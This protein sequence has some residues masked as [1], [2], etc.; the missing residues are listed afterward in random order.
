MLARWLPGFRQVSS[1]SP[2]LLPVNLTSTCGNALFFL[3]LADPPPCAANSRN[4]LSAL[5]ARSHP[6]ITE[7]TPFSTTPAVSPLLNHFLGNLEL[8]WNSKRPSCTKHQTS[9]T[10]FINHLCYCAGSFLSLVPHFLVAKSS[11]SSRRPG[12]P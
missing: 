9:H 8:A 10:P 6:W 4:A 11:L 12:L 2:F 5:F 3:F 1:P 7:L